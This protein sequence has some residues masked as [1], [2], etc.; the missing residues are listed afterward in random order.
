MTP[1]PAGKPT[2]L[3]SSSQIPYCPHGRGALHP[4]QAEGKQQGERDKDKQEQKQRRLSGEGT[5]MKLGGAFLITTMTPRQRQGG[6]EGS[7]RNN[8]CLC[9]EEPLPAAPFQ[10]PARLKR[11]R[12]DQWQLQQLQGRM[13]THCLDTFSF[14]SFFFLDKYS[15]RKST[16]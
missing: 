5:K 4:E 6:D 13:L 16:R 14:G 11:L 2:V 12:P 1:N 7:G 15:K 9:R 8:K 3:F 10:Q